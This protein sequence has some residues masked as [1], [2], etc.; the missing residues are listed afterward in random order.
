ME[1]V[2]QT[3]QWWMEISSK[4]SIHRCSSSSLCSFR[5]LK[6]VDG[7]PYSHNSSLCFLD[8]GNAL[9]KWILLNGELLERRIQCIIKEDQRHK[10]QKSRHSQPRN[11]SPSSAKEIQI[12]MISVDTWEMPKHSEQ[13]RSWK[14]SQR[15]KPSK[16]GFFHLC[17]IARWC[18]TRRDN[19]IDP[20]MQRKH[21]KRVLIS[22]IQSPHSL[23]LWIWCASPQPTN[24]QLEIRPF[25]RWKGHSNVRTP[26]STSFEMLKS[27]IST[28]QKTLKKEFTHCI[29]NFKLNYPFSSWMSGS[30]IDSRVE[31]STNDRS[32]EGQVDIR[33]DQ[34]PPDLSCIHRS[35]HIIKWLSLDLKVN[36]EGP[37][38]ELRSQLEACICSTVW[39]ST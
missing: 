26:F 35:P 19:T 3:V 7:L 24:I 12:L 8:H 6:F 1:S 5:S 32:D 14:R 18:R 13:R 39:W 2:N 28:F 4:S 31:N 30:Y 38:T 37:R 25:S 17:C 11:I 15:L 34:I 36:Q 27:S 22:E 29:Y 9:N 33:L 23:L 16:L 10:E 20:W 21:R